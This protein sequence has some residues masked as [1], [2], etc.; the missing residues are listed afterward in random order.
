MCAHSLSWLRWAAL[1]AAL[2]AGS[3]HA[4]SDA[5]PAEVQKF[6]APAAGG[7]ALGLLQLTGSLLTVLAVVFAVAWAMRRLQLT[8]RTQ[9]GQLQVLAQL[10]LGARERAVLVQVGPRQLLLGVAAGSITTLHVLD[11]PLV[12]TEAHSS[13]GVDFRAVLLRSLGRS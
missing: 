4:A 8:G 6:A 3:A 10:P 9:P 13:A 7:E 11:E 2:L 1:A 12:M 5:S